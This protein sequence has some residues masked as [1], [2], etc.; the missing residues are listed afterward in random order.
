MTKLVLW[1]SSPRRISISISNFRVRRG[2]AFEVAMVSGFSRIARAC[3][4]LA[5]LGFCF[6]AGCSGN[7]NDGGEPPVIQYTEVDDDGP[8]PDDDLADDDDSGEFPTTPT[9]HVESWNCNIC[10]E[11]DFYE[12]KGEPHGGVFAAPDRC[13]ACHR[14]GSWSFTDPNAPPDHGAT[15]DCLV[16]HATQHGKEFTDGAQCFTC[17]ATGDQTSDA[18]TGH[19]STWDCNI[20]HEEDFLGAK[21]EPHGGDFEAPGGC[22]NCHSVGDWIYTNPAA[23]DGHGSSADCRT[24]HADQHQ[25][26]W[27]DPAQCLVCHQAGPTP[28]SPPLGHS[29][30][31]NCYIC[32]EAPFNGAPGEPHGGAH[33]APADCIACHAQGTWVY[34]NPNAPPGH[35]STQD[36]LT[37]HANEHTKPWQ[38]MTQC[39]L[40]HLDGPTPPELALGHDST[41]TCTICHEADFLGA[42]GEPHSG[43]YTPPGTCLVCHT[44]GSWI[45]TNP[46]APA[47]HESAE[48][49]LNCHQGKHG[50]T[51]EAQAQCYMCHVAG[52]GGQNFP[53]GHSGSWN[54][55]ICHA[56]DFLGANGEPH[57]GQHAAPADCLGCHE[58]GSWTYTNPAAPAGH[59]SSGNCLSCHQGLHG[60]TWQEGAQCFACHVAGNQ[61]PGSP[62]G[63]SQTWNCYICHAAPFLGTNGEPHGG[64]HTAPSDCLN[65]HQLG[66]WVYTNP[67]AP[68]GHGSAEDCLNCHS[69]KHGKTW[70]EF[71]QCF[72]CHQAGTAPSTYPVGHNGVWN[73]Y[74]C[75]AADFLGANGEPHGG[76]HTAPTE[77]LTC[78]V[79]GSWT[80]TNP[81]APP[82]HG[83]TQSCLNCHATQHGKTWTDPAQCA[84]CHLAGSAGPQ[85]SNKHRTTW[86]CYVCH[87][88]AFNGAP[89]EPHSGR[90]AAPA[91][92]LACHSM[93]SFSNPRHGPRPNSDHMPTWN[94]LSCHATRHGKPWQDNNQ[95]MLCHQF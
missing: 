36:C 12:A 27:G 38:E 34:T 59:G 39:Q 48:P 24:C 78:H 5:A 67:N 4:Y 41:W 62:T 49:C 1:F 22:V 9:G 2:R 21:G 73:C 87:Q 35:G 30:T 86:N 31:W 15:G 68:A 75:H 56:A 93:G 60:K 3:G 52:S 46:N 40:C 94:C 45:Y 77:C 26:T 70:Q 90:Y 81:N 50:K 55:Y 92:C 44:Q 66:T 28:P 95:C 85:F 8:Y 43:A 72:A 29:Q 88:T 23:P 57:S 79:A 17:H 19:I 83:S 71:A 18:P 13:V 84:V 51:W 6:L 7:W 47:A 63:H 14:E 16:C 65:C 10:H 74:L 42:T 64:E 76:E 32:H 69:G 33:T 80:Y 54:C 20:C 25:K 91:D 82:G 89:R 58:Q 11:D 61:P 53:V 37:C